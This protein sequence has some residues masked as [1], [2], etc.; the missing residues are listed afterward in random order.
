MSITFNTDEIFEIAEE[1]ERQA[2]RLYKDAQSKASDEKTKELLGE[3]SHMEENHMKIFHE[4]RSHLSQQDKEET[5]Y[6]PDNQAVLYLQA[7]AD[8]HGMEGKKGPDKPLTGKES[9]RE[10]LEIACGAEKN[11]IVFYHSIME[12]VK[13]PSGKKKVNEI[14]HEEFRHLNTLQDYLQAEKRSG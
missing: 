5:V 12:Y 8:S 14:I 2:M 9:I 10:L 7:M 13:S 1:M 4:M 3:F 6:D 11:S